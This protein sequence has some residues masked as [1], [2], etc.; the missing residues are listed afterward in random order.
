MSCCYSGIE[1]WG[2][3]C[4]PPLPIPPELRQPMNP[5]HYFRISKPVD[6]TSNP[7]KLGGDASFPQNAQDASPKLDPSPQ[8][9]E[10]GQLKT[11]KIIFRHTARCVTLPASPLSRHGGASFPQNAQNAP[12]NLDPPPQPSETK[13]LMPPQIIIRHTPSTSAPT[14]TPNPHPQPPHF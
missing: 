13:G 10:K 6:P 9:T 3:A 7:P 11:P 14:P 4:R 5:F 1:G 2:A 12:P 8:P